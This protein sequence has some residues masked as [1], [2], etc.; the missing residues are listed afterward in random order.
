MSETTSVILSCGFFFQSKNAP[1][2]RAVARGPDTSSVFYRTSTD[3]TSPP[4][5]LASRR[6]LAQMRYTI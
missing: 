1:R 5:L 4:L 6:V 2:R 3:D